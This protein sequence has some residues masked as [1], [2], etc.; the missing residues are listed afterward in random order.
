MTAAATDRPGKERAYLAEAAAAAAAVARTMC[1]REGGGAHFASF[2]LPRSKRDGVF[3]VWAMARLIERAIAAETAAGAA[4]G[5]GDCCGG[6]CKVAPLLKSRL[7]AVYAGTLELPR[8]EFADE[9][10]QVLAAAA[11]TVRQYEVPR[12]AWMS[13]IDALAGRCGLARVATWKSLDERVL[14]PIGGS[15][16]RMSAAVLG[17]THSDAADFASRVGRGAAVASVLRDLKRDAAANRILLPLED[18]ARFRYSDRDMLCLT[19]N[20]S[21]RALVRHAAERART[22]LED[23]AAATGW[24]AD[25]GSRMLVAAFVADRL[26]FLDAVAR[27]PEMLFRDDLASRRPSLVTRLRLLPAAWRIAR[28][29]PANVAPAPLPPP[30]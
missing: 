17:A 22:L 18:C 7:D 11:A 26:R 8:P 21:F 4:A 25:D 20:D 9:S 15:V 14:T 1:R 13:L 5:G 16:G 28:R 23:G 6:D 10:Q 19:V 24:L 3:A 27:E 29:Q 30:L 12:D 2:F